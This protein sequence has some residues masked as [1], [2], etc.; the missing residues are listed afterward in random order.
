MVIRSRLLQKSL[1]IALVMCLGISLLWTN[2]QKAEAHGDGHHVEEHKPTYALVMHGKA[3]YSADFTHFD[4]VNP[5]APKGGLL[6][7]SG[8]ETFDNLNGFISK[9]VAASGTDLIY[10]SLLTKSQDEPFTM[11]GDIAETIDTTEDRS[12]VIFKI[13][14]EAIWHDG[15]PITAEDVVWT[16]HTL[17]EKG[18]PFYKAYY[19]HVENVEAISEKEV[20]FTFSMAHNREL[21][22]IV[23]EMNILPKHYWTAEGRDFSAT[24]LV[25]PLGSGPY[26][27]GKIAPG[28]SL[29]YLRVKDWWAKDLPVNKGRY[30]FDRI[31]Y[32]YYRDQNV[33]LEALFANEYDF[34]QEYTAKLWATAYDVPAV[35]KGELKKELIPNALPQGMQGFVMNIRRPVFKDLAVRKAMDLAFDYEWSNKQFAYGAYVRTRSYF[36]NSEMAATGLPEG[37]ELEILEQFRNQLP[38]HVFTEEYNPSK[39][40]GSGNNRKNLR[41]AIKLLEGAGYVMGENGVRV[42]KETGVELRFEFLVANTNAAFQRWFSP[43]KQNLE[44]IGIIGDIRIVDASQYINRILDFDYDM[45]VSSWGQSTSPGNEQREFW[46]SEKA[47]ISGSRNYIGVKDPVVDALIELIVSAPSRED[48]VIR[49]RALDRVLQSGYYVVPNWHLAAWRIAYWDTFGKPETQAPY[50]LGYTDTWWK[51][52]EAE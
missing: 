33:S 51:K 28:Q 1:F 48:L 41:E 16:F 44:R 4:Y 27:F 11:Y 10:Q 29:E 8:A 26:K 30:N 38:E 2:A 35:K 40:D 7:L 42:H 34:R 14:D 37:K 15:K 21:P 32:D 47:D 46:N 23:G 18:S 39:T 43:Y 49:C 19:A 22:L 50:S 25:P 5:D 6:R 20:K 36:E 9:G 24:T 12:W 13:R 31:T 45:I 17:T 52:P 3:K